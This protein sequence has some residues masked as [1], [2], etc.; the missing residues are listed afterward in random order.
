[1]LPTAAQV[2][3]AAHRLRGVAD[4]TP[5]IHS[6]VL[7][8]LLGAD[9]YLKCEQLQRTGSFKLRGAYNAIAA[10]PRD[11]R[12]RGIVASSAGNHG[13]GVAHAARLLG[14]RAR[15]FVP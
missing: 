15:I 8:E 6:A 11:V 14:T 9:V 7:S 5:L 4:R 1:M 10:L 2:I 3:A 13:L 12:Q